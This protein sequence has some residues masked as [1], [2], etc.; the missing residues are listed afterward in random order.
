MMYH[1]PE[2]Y[3]ARNYGKPFTHEDIHILEDI[4]SV[5][6]PDGINPLHKE[7]FEICM[8]EGAKTHPSTLNEAMD[9]LVYLLDTIQAEL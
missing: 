5:E 1:F 4:L 9:L 6:I 3:G 7:L 8:A 2:L